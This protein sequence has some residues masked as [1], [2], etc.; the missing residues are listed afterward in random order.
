MRPLAHYL[1]APISYLGRRTISCQV[2]V[3]LG[4][5]R[6]FIG[7]LSFDLTFC[8]LARALVND[9]RIVVLDECTAAVDVETVSDAR[10]ALLF[11]SY[12]SALTAV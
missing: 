8:S 4:E 11:F 7:Y 5:Y 1:H 6:C 9:A 3:V 12:E 10:R 2:C